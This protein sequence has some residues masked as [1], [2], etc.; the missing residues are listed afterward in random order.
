[1]TEENNSILTQEEKSAWIMSVATGGGV[2]QTGLEMREL[3][4]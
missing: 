4:I 1:M 2:P 3:I